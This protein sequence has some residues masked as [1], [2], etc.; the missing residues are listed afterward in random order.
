MLSRIKRVL[1]NA[2]LDY[3]YAG[4]FLGGTER[5]RFANQGATDIASSNY[6]ET[7]TI[8][9]DIV[10]PDDVLVDVGCG[11]GRV[12]VSW[13]HLGLKNK[14]I[15]VELDDQVGADTRRRMRGYANIEIVTGSVVD[16]LP[17]EGS[18]Y[19]LFNPFGP[20]VMSQFKSALE[21]ARS[22]HGVRVICHGCQGLRIFGEDEKW[23]Q[24]EIKKPG[25]SKGT[26][27]FSLGEVGKAHESL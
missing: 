25:L 2:F 21:S 22:E 14:L 24:R 10:R 19:Y 3:R 26:Y 11:K 13:L 15:G 12:L 8:F 9:Q 4:E 16:K 7:I 23:H 17:R 20:E 1:R 18:L 6:L 27:L 5:T